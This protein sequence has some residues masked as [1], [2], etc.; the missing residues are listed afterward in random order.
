MEHLVTG[1][2]SLFRWFSLEW[3]ATCCVLRMGAGKRRIPALPQAH[4]TICARERCNRL[5]ALAIRT[6]QDAEGM[7]NDYR[8]LWSFK[9]VPRRTK[10]SVQSGGGK[11]QILN[12]D[13]LSHERKTLSIPKL[14]EERRASIRR[15]AS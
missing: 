5:H 15:T 9:W 12:K 14:R 3:P 7:E 11:V 1:G 13:Q 4:R 8:F 10:Y 6:A 2:V